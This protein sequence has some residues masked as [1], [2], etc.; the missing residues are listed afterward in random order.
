MP[1]FAEQGIAG[2]EFDTWFGFLVARGTPQAIIGRLAL[3]TDA[4]LRRPDVRENLA[5]QGADP[6]GG[7]PE[8]FGRLLKEEF[9]RWPR[10]LKAAGITR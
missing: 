10:E 1:T 6:I 4:A 2:Y 7:T 3:A 8:D 9:L 5:A